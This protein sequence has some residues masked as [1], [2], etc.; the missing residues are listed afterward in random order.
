MGGIN[1]K[2]FSPIFKIFYRTIYGFSVYTLC[3]TLTVA[4]RL[5]TVTLYISVNVVAT[6]VKKIYIFLLLLLPQLYKNICK[7]LLLLLTQLYKRYIFMLLLLLQLYEIYIFLLLLLLQLYDKYFCYCSCYNCIIHI[8]VIVVATTV[9]KRYISVSVVATAVWKIYYCYCCCYNCMKDIILLF[10]LLQLYE[11]CY[12]CCY[13]CMKE[14]I[15]QLQLYKRCYCCCY[16]CMKDVIVV[17]TA[18]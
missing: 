9:W 5:K 11:R 15:E 14:V 7:F 17:A 4:I 10:L 12:C 16:S 2:I 8:S 13:S 1:N 3:Y 6:T 18:V